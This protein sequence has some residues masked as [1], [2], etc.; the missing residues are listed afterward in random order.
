MRY[1]LL[2]FVLAFGFTYSL[3]HTNKIKLESVSFKLSFCEQN[4][5]K[6]ASIR[7]KEN[8]NFRNTINKQN[9]IISKYKSILFVEPVKQIPK[10]RIQ[11]EVQKLDVNNSLVNILNFMYIY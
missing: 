9:K 8:D 2:F 10:E 3:Y 1:A 5:K 4:Q 7:Q 11:C 6:I